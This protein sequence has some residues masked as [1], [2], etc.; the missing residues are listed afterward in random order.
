MRI[1]CS[2]LSTEALVKRYSRR[3][4]PADNQ[5]FVRMND[6]CKRRRNTHSNRIK[7]INSCEWRLFFPA[8]IFYTRNPWAGERIFPHLFSNDEVKLNKG[9]F[10]YFS[11]RRDR[12]AR[13]FPNGAAFTT[14]LK[15]WNSLQQKL[16]YDWTGTGHGGG[17]TL[18]RRTSPSG[19]KFVCIE[20]QR[21]VTPA[22]LS[23]TTDSRETRKKNFNYRNEINK[24]QYG[25]S[26]GID[27]NERAG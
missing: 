27:G 12:E 15:T 16:T 7:S 1:W 10:L 13:A 20:L 25:R 3:S 14:S 6:S 26:S 8:W 19:N 11:L 4:D 21:Y 24:R 18:T 9:K 17:K 5:T 23:D 22:S 2:Y